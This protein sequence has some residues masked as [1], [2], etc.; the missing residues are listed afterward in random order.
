MDFIG[1]GGPKMQARRS[2]TGAALAAILFI[3][4][5]A[6]LWIVIPGN[7]EIPVSGERIAAYGREH[8]PKPWHG[9]EATIQEVSIDSEV[10]IKAHVTGHLI[11]TPVVVSGTPQYDPAARVMFFRVS[12]VELP[13]EASRPMLGELN[14]MLT[15]LGTNIAKHMTDV[16]PVKHLKPEKRGEAVFMETVKSVHIANNA[17]VLEVHGYFFTAAAGA[18]V[19]LA[20]L[21]AIWFVVSLLPRRADA[22]NPQP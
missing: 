6:G 18:L 2:S 21:S 15:P 12:K 20:L 13:H 3:A 22:P 7:A 8:P 9:F 5:L 4:T 14:K 17:L 1:I 16:I 10:H 19:A 11:H